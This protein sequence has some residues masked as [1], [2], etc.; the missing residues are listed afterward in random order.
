MAVPV[1]GLAVYKKKDG[2]LTISK[3]QQSVQWTSLTSTVPSVVI[4]VAHISSELLPFLK[5]KNHVD[6]DKLRQTCNK[7]QNQLR[8]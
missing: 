3:D 4:A 7:P 6:I 5:K 2:T 1:K 8:R